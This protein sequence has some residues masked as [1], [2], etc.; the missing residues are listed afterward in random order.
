MKFS[1]PVIHEGIRHHLKV[2][3]PVT[4]TRGQRGVIIHILED[5]CGSTKA[6]KTLLMWFFPDT[7]KSLDQVTSKALSNDQWYALRR[8]IDP[9]KV[10]KGYYRSR[11]GEDFV[12]ECTEIWMHQA[13]HLG[14]I[15]IKQI[16]PEG[17]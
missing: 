15:V 1:L 16:E 17:A 8:W 5:A 11:R 2:G 12:Q 6:R 7:F 9:I 10:R 4:I 13:E 3:A 14:E